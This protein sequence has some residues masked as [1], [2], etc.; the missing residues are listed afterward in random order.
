MPLQLFIVL[1]YGICCWMA[2]AVIEPVMRSFAVEAGMASWLFVAIPGLLAMLFA[3]LSYIRA[4]TQVTTTE[5]SLSRALLVALLTWIAI[6]SLIAWLWCPWHNALRCFS[7]TL[8]TTG[9]VGGG[10]LLI[11]SMVAGGVVAAVLKLR[12]AWVEFGD[13]PRMMAPTPEP[14]PLSRPDAR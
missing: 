9:I 14:S 6:T 5:H 1:V 12:P 10:P 13:R 4:A 8:I 3:V 7:N 11:G 2:L